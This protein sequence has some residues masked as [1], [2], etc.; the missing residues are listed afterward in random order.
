MP[1]ILKEQTYEDAILSGPNGRIVWNAMQQ[2]DPLRRVWYDDQTV[3]YFS[4][5]TGRSILGPVHPN[6]VP[7]FLCPHCGHDVF[8]AA[9]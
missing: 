2:D 1:K 9:T 3:Q 7:V 6:D 4:T 5:K 8:G